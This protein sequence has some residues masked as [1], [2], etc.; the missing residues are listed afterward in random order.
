MPSIWGLAASSEATP[1]CSCAER[2]VRRVPADDLDAGE[3]AEHALDL[4]V[5][6]FRDRRAGQA[7]VD[8]DLALA[9]QHIGEPGRDVVVDAVPVGVELIGARRGHHLAEA[10]HDDAGGAGRLDGRVECRSYEAAWMTIAS[11]L[12]AMM[13]LS[14]LICAWACVL[15]GLDV[16]VDA[17]RQRPLVTDTSAERCIC[18][19][20]SLPIRPLDR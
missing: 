19:S 18:C 12:A 17:A 6:G 10:D 16:Q 11:G 7:A 2:V 5:R 20:Q 8:D 3:L 4:L 1:A 14:E 13:L 15:D 9:A